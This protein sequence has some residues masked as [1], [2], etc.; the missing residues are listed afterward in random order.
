MFLNRIRLLTRTNTIEI[1]N[2][3]TN[4]S[5]ARL[6]PN[7][8]A[9]RVDASGFITRIREVEDRTRSRYPRTMLRETIRCRE[10]KIR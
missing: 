4:R 8:F 5:V 7:T 10:K 3:Y 2:R 6:T 1:N 9:I